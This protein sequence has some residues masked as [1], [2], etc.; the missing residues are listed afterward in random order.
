MHTPTPPPTPPQPHPLPVQALAAGD[1]SE[2]PSS[3]GAVADA[4]GDAAAVA[5]AA[6]AAAMASEG[7]H[8]VPLSLLLAGG[9]LQWLLGRDAAA[10]LVVLETRQDLPSEVVL[11]LL[12]G[13]GWG[14]VE[15]ALTGF[16]RPRNIR[17]CVWGGGGG[18]AGLCA[19]SLEV[20]ESSCQ[21]LFVSCCYSFV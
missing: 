19:V 13:A 15:S 21:N 10:S 7:P 9:G 8:K 20:A 4:Q 6:A 11:Q 14:C 1:L 5:V 12:Q 17:M 2:A 18:A 16:D 3:T